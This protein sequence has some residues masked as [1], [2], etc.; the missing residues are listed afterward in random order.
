MDSLVFT[1]NKKGEYWAVY[2]SES[3][4]GVS[5]IISPYFFDREATVSWFEKN[6][7]ELSDIWWERNKKEE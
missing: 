3:D 5:T 4:Y 7:K 1:I 2:A 6:K